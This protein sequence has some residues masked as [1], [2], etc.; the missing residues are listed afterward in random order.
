MSLSLQFKHGAL[1]Y[2]LKSPDPKQSLSLK[3]NCEEAHTDHYL[4]SNK[5]MKKKEQLNGY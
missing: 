5:K 1:I 2:I 4:L 3:Q